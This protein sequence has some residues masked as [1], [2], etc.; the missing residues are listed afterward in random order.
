MLF[1]TI[2]GRFGQVR[3]SAEDRLDAIRGC[4]TP[5]RHRLHAAATIGPLSFSSGHAS[6]GLVE[7]IREVVHRDERSGIAAAVQG[8]PRLEH[9][10]PHLHALGKGACRR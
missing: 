8:A 10:E 4:K 6:A 2:L 5:S 1:V 9:F 3:G 7:G